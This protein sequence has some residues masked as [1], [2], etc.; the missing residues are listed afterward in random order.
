MPLMEV[1]ISQVHCYLNKNNK[2]RYTEVDD[3]RDILGEKYQMVW[4]I[5]TDA[6]EDRIRYLH[7]SLS[8]AKVLTTRGL[9]F[10]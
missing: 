7:L 3:P 6:E 10:N 1:R 8:K 2:D 9:K 4:N 5:I